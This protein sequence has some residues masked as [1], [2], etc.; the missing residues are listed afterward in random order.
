MKKIRSILLKWL[1]KNTW[2]TCKHD[3]SCKMAGRWTQG[4]VCKKCN[5]QAL[6]I[7]GEMLIYINI[8][9]NAPLRFNPW[10]LNLKSTKGIIIKE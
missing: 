6:S 9:N 7:R 10:G 3:F 2:H 4:Y 5:V 1:L 8:D